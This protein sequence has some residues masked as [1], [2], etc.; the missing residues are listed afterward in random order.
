MTTPVAPLPAGFR[1]VL[2]TSARR[3][4]ADSWLGGS[5]ARVIRL[6]AA[7]QAAWQELATG[8]V[9]SP[10][11]GALARRLTDA[12]L[13][14][15]RPPTPRHD[16]DVTVVIPVHDRVDKLARCLAAVGDR[17][18]VVLVDDGSREPGAIIE[19]ADR[20]GAKVIRRPVNGGPAAA[21]NTG[22]AATAGELVAFVDSDCVPPTGWIGALAAHFADPLVG[23]VAP[24]TVPVPG[25]PGG[26]AGRYAGTTRSLDL[27]GTPARVGSNTRVAYVPTAAILVRRAAL[28][29]IAG[30]GPAAGGA[31]D[32]TLSVAGEDVDLVW[33]L[34]K[35]GWR[36]R[37]DPT[38]EVRHLEPETWAGLLGRRFRYG[39]SAAPLAL[40]HPG[41]L[42]PLV[43][44]PGPALTVAA[45][46]ARRPALAAAAYT[47]SVLRTVRTLR[48]SDLPVREVARATAG[49]VGRTWLGVGRYGTQYALPL[50]AAG[51]AGGGR[52]RWGRRAAVASLVVGPALAEWAGRRGSMDPVRFVLG[53]LAEDVAYGSGVWTGCVHNRTTIPVRPTIGRRAHGSRGPD[54]R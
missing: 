21:R 19:L 35:A 53:R 41:S 36:I 11:A 8:P 32:T 40:R 54:H 4:S 38:V 14:H 25:A 1:V 33:R 13:A 17:H 6:T 39:T 7:G 31:F 50:L 5:P 18:P 46:L 43:L 45:L 24:R 10:R 51:A 26:W 29:E 44:F 22:L 23:A 9:V 12:G 49:A 27:G 48:R 34:D 16:P 20:F 28:A 2:D 47:C 42:P 3:L 52:R 37:Y 15:P 30:G